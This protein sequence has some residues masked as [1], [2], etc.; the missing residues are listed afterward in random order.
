M[1]RRVSAQE[2]RRRFAEILGHVRFA[3]EPVVI[4][5]GGQEYVAMVPLED[6]ARMQKEREARFRRLEE[7]WERMPPGLDPEEV[8]RHV[9]EEL[10]AVR[11]ERRRIEPSNG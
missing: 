2:A 5:K 7:L 9:E 8:E 6:F 3:K 10:R 4:E 11:Q 1:V